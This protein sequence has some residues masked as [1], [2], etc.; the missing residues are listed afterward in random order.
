MAES[1]AGLPPQV[2]AT[3]V[4]ILDAV[5]GGG[6]PRGTLAI[7]VGPPGSGKMTLACQIAF[8]SG[9]AG[10]RAL[11]LTA[12]SEP[13]SKLVA[14]LLTFCFFDEALLGGSVEVVSLEQLWSA[15]T[16]TARPVAGRGEGHGLPSIGGTGGR[17]G[18]PGGCRNGRVGAGNGSLSW[19]GGRGASV[20]WRAGIGRCA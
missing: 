5:L 20:L 4:P 14:H 7:V 1:E 11:I 18:S 2:D 17:L 3:V 19:R 8:A 6:L 9:R 15:T 13:T 12:L 10:R 16:R